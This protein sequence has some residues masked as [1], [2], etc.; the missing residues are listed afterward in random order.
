MKRTL[1]AGL[2][3][4]VAASAGAASE[5]DVL[6]EAALERAPVVVDG[7]VLAEVRG[8]AGRPAGERA[9]AIEARIVAAA[10]DPD[11]DPAQL[12]VVESPEVSRIQAGDRLIMGVFDA[13]AELEQMNR[14]AL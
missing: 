9:D 1:A 8:V 13:D 3:A 10:Q 7:H 4:L 6:S 11:F 14:Q 12:E 5:T 2:L